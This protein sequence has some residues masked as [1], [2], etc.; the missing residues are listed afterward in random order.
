MAF[1]ASRSFHDGL[2][3]EEALEVLL[4]QRIE[5]LLPAIGVGAELLADL[6]E[7]AGLQLE[8]AERARAEHP[9]R[10]ADAIEEADLGLPTG[11]VA[12][13]LVDVRVGDLR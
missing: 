8:L 13:R 7:D 10:R 3:V 4:L 12:E 11:A 6:R 1:G 2:R 5:R 9:E